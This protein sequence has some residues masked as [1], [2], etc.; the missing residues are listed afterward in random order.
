MNS[1]FICTVQSG[2]LLRF[3]AKQTYLTA[4]SSPASE[5]NEEEMKRISPCKDTREGE[6]VS[7]L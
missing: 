7:A 3:V 5:K 6:C 1:V 2:V 4:T